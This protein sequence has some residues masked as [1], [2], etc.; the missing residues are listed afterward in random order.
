MIE[1]ALM[2][3]GREIE[4]VQRHK[5]EEDIAVAAA[6]ILARD[7]FVKGLAKLEKQFNVKLPKGASTVVDEAARKFV[8]ERGADDL[9][10]V[11]KI[12]FRTAFRAQ[13][14]PEPPKTEWRK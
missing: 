6:S 8:A 1:K 5:A 12:H 13:G 2:S 9:P 7:E 11:A 3:A 10:K 4:L 14:L